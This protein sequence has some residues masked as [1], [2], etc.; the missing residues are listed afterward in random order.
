[1]SDENVRCILADRT[2]RI[3]GMYTERCSYISPTWH[4]S[5]SYIRQV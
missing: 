4:W 1:M 2:Q 3:Y 5:E